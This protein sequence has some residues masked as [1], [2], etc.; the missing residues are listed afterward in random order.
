MYIGDLGTYDL[1]AERAELLKDIRRTVGRSALYDDPLDSTS[2]QAATPWA[3]YL[4]TVIRYL[5]GRLL[6]T[7]RLLACTV[8][9]EAIIVGVGDYDTAYADWKVYHPEEGA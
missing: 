1:T 2:E 3:K 4:H 7:E 8:P 5:V 9:D 6:A